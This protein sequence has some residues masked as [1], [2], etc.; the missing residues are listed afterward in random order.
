MSG[1]PHPPTPPPITIHNTRAR[2]FKGYNTERCTRLQRSA[3]PTLQA[4][5]GLNRDNA[6]L[7]IPT[8]NSGRHA[9]PAVQNATASKESV[10]RGYSLPDARTKKKNS[11][12]RS[13]TLQNEILQLV[14]HC[15]DRFC[16][17]FILPVYSPSVHRVSILRRVLCTRFWFF[18]FGEQILAERNEDLPNVK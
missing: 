11:N 5:W 9:L 8:V 12:L 13:L 16:E 15:V 6:S 14:F 18:L 2:S 4:G 10:F 17:Q 7:A 3:T 1:D